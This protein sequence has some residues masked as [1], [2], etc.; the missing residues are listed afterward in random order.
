MRRRFARRRGQ[1]V[2]QTWHGTPLKRLALH[3]PGFD[4][5]RAAA[6]IKESRRW[7]VLL[8]QNPYAGRILRKAYAFL[9]RPVW[10]EGYPRDDVLR[11][12][13]SEE[14]TSELQSLMRT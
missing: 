7:N 12:D 2:L 1:V 11:G 4:L 9:R 10:V 3:R 6:V 14:H 8:A 13:R 5:R